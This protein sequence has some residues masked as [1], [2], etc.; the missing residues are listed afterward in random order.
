MFN[1]I[2]NK[3]RSI[4]HIQIK[5][6]NGVDVIMIGDFYQTPLVKD[7]WIFQNIKDNVNTLTLNF[8]QTYVQ[9]YQLNKII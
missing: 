1:V 3:L 2:N 9:C 5:L 7:S 6:F 4:K 8:W